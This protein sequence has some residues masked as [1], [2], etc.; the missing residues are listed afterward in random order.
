MAMLPEHD[1]R[2]FIN[3]QWIQIDEVFPY[4]VYSPSSNTEHHQDKWRWLVNV[5]N[6]AYGED[7]M[8]RI[9]LGE[10][11]YDVWCFKDEGDAIAFCLKWS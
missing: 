5:L 8:L 4:G 1:G 6:L 3:N 2:T 7:W 11:F 10:S 9:P